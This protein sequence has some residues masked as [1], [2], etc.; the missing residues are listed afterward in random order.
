MENKNTP[1]KEKELIGQIVKKTGLAEEDIQKRIDEKEKEFNGLVSREGAIYIIGKEAGINIEKPKSESLKIKNIAPNM[2]QVNI[3]AKVIYISPIREFT[4]SKGD[5]KVK[6]ITLGDETGTITMSVWNDDI[7]KIKDITEEE[8]IQLKNCYSKNGYMDKTEIVFSSRS[9]MEKIDENIEAIKTETKSVSVSNKHTVNSLHSVKES[10]F[11]KIQACLISAFEKK[12]VHNLCPECRKK[13]DEKSNC[14]VHGK[15]KPEK[16]LIISATIDDG[17]GTID[18]VLFNNAVESLLQKKAEE[19][20]DETKEMTT[21][22]YLLN[23]NVL[24]KDFMIE[25]IIKKNKFTDSEELHIQVVNE[26]NIGS[27]I[28]EK[29]K[30]LEI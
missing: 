8:V 5:G 1:D 25:G 2:R 26:L 6:N 13:I 7:E 11:V 9:D 22:N 24:G 23:R 29:T 17:Y 10:D 18:A 14:L 19:I 28:K 27:S 12:I 20:E 16:F 3:V 4:T 21:T 15:V 30:E